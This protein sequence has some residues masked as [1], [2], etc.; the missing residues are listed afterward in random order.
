MSDS[1]PEN[2]RGVRQ[3]VSRWSTTHRGT[4]TLKAAYAQAA[5]DVKRMDPA[6]REAIGRSNMTRSDLQQIASRHVDAQFRPDRYAGVS[7]NLG[8]EVQGR[9]AESGPAPSRGW[10]A[11]KNPFSRWNRNQRQ[12][13]KA[14]KAALTQ[15]ARDV[16]RTDPRVRWEIGR[17]HVN[18]ADLA[19][20]ASSRM[21]HLFRPEGRFQGVPGQQQNGAGRQGQGQ[22]IQSRDAVLQAPSPQQSEQLN[23]R[24][25]TLQQAILEAQ[26]QTLTL[27]EENNRLQGEMRQL[28]EARVQQLQQENAAD[29]AQEPAQ[30]REGDNQLVAGDQ[31]PDERRTEGEAQRGEA[32]TGE[33]RATGEAEVGEPRAD[34]EAEVGEAGEPRA[35]GEAEVGEAG[36]PRTAGEAEVGEAGEPR[37]T[38][39][40]EVGEVGEPRTAGEAEVGEPRAVGGA[41]VGPEVEGAGVQAPAGGWADSAATQGQSVRDA[42][43][44]ASR[45]STG[46]LDAPAATTQDPA[47][48]PATTVDPQQS[49]TNPQQPSTNPQ[50]PGTNTQQAGASP[51]QPR[52]DVQP[53]R[54]PAAGEKTSAELD[55]KFARDIAFNGS[56]PLNSVSSQKTEE[57]VKA[58]GDNDAT[59]R[60][61]RGGQ[62][63]QKPATGNTQKPPTKRD[64]R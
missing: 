35:T 57:A 20:L 38:G 13:T 50:Q 46:E 47:A 24:I 32:Q 41:E 10:I 51:Q 37:A 54:G 52:F 30:Q 33:P 2:P 22:G 19:A 17:S 25:A 14:L 21:D 16:K 12:G 40:A 60:Q 8:Q 36:E 43:A 42:E 44:L 18:S 58:G 34:G 64:G 62:A 5:R 4:K 39:E 6:V 45:Q 7:R 11:R 53:Q 26:Q 28:L 15:A 31:Q 29:P 48:T 55:S 63:P 1:Y 49:G 23:Q 59:K 9:L 27:M 61:Q 56:T 3:R